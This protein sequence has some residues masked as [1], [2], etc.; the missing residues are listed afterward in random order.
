[1]HPFLEH[2][3]PPGGHVDDRGADRVVA[4][5]DLDTLARCQAIEFD[6]DGRVESLPPRDRRIGR[7][8]V[9]PGVRRPGDAEGDGEVA[10]VALRRL[11]PG[12]VCPRT[13]TGHTE[14]SA[15][16]G[17]PVGEQRLR[18]GDDEVVGSDLVIGRRGGEGHVMTGLAARPGDRL[19]TATGTQHEDSH[20]PSTPSKANLAWVASTGIGY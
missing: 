6:D 5:G 2:E 19:L 10:A 4:V 12:E 18:T 9:E 7:A 15:A 14:R 20:Q 11:E 8:G 17:D 13:E 16:V 3:R 1:M